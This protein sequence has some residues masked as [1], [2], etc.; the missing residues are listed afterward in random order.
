[1]LWYSLITPK[2]TILVWNEGYWSQNCHHRLLRAGVWWWL[3][4]MSSNLNLL[5]PFIILIIRYWKG[6]DAMNCPHQS[7]L[8]ESWCERWKTGKP[9]L[10]QPAK[11]EK[12]VVVTIL[13]PTH[14]SQPSPTIHHTYNEKLKGLR[15]CD[16]LRS[17]QNTQSWCEM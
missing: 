4:R 7:K 6:Q 5:Q 9:T 3:W 2:H 14:E 15:C 11:T 17:I 10:D 13:E 8:T 12:H 16:I 1:M